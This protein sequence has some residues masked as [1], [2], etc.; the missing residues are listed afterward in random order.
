MS[1][2]DKI[3]EDVRLIHDKI[4]FLNTEKMQK[5]LAGYTASEV[6]CLEY[7]GKEEDVNVTK[8][9]EHFFMTRGA[10]SKISK[11]LTTKGAITSYKKSENKK[12]IYFELTEEGK[13]IF[14]IHEGLHAEFRKRDEHLF[15]A[16]PED[17]LEKVESF[18][19]RYNEHLNTEIENKK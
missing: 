5:A 6:H 1:N 7:I 14:D 2:I 17:V 18:L 3:F 13:R 16:I 10:M 9:A 12:E 19:T 8:L 15:E 4:L 11:K